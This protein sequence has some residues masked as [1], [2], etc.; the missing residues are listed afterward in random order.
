[1]LRLRDEHGA[2]I[3]TSNRALK[4]WPALLNHD[5]PLPAAVLDRLLHHADTIII[6]GKSCR[7]QDPLAR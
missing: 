6:A 1:V 7:M 3:L 4:E 5:R 2:L